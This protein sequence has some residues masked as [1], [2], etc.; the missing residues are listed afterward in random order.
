MF[1]EKRRWAKFDRTTE[2]HPKTTTLGKSLGYF[3]PK[4]RTGIISDN[5]EVNHLFRIINP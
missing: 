3:S 1:G 4:H 5:S 2:R